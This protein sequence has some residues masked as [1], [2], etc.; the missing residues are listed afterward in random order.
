[1]G[2]DI[3][4]PDIIL[5]DYFQELKTRLTRDSKIFNRKEGK[6][7]IPEIRRFLCFSTNTLNELNQIEGFSDGLINDLIPSESYDQFLKE[8]FGD[9]SFS[10]N[11]LL[12]DTID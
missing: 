3:F 2:K 9:R 11:S 4:S 12:V 5:D 6:L 8:L 7:L 10:M 1:D